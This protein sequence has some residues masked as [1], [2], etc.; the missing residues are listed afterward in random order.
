MNKLKIVLL[1][2]AYLP[3]AI[4]ALGN[5]FIIKD[6]I[7]Y[8]IKSLDNSSM[9][10]SRK[11]WIDDEKGK[12]YGKVVIE[13]NEFRKSKSIKARILSPTGKTLKKLKK[14]NIRVIQ[15]S[16]PGL[17]YTG[18]TYRTF[19]LS[20]PKTPYIIEYTYTIQFK[21]L[22]YWPNWFPQK[23]IS[24]KNAKYILTVPANIQYQKKVIGDISEPRHSGNNSLVWELSN[25][26]ASLNEYRTAPEDQY[27]YAILFSPSEFTLDGIRGS[28]SSWNDMGNWYSRLANSQYELDPKI[29]YDLNLADSLTTK[30]TIQRIYSYLQ[31][32]TRYVAVTLGIHGWK[33]HTAQS[34]CDNKYGDCKDLTTYFISLLKTQNI[35]AFPAL[36]LTRDKGIVYPD[37]PTSRFNHVITFIPLE[38]ETLWVDCTTD[39]TNIMDLPAN[40][41]GCNALVVKYGSGE[42]ISTPVS[43]PDDN[44]LIFRAD[45]RLM[46]DGSVLFRGSLTGTGN[47]AQYFRVVFSSKNDEDKRNTL[48]T[49]LGDNVPLIKLKEMVFDSS[50]SRT[51]TMKIEFEFLAAKYTNM[52]R[53][54]LFLS[55]SF[56][57]RTQYNYERPDKRQTA[58]FYKYPYIFKDFISYTISDDF[59]I[60]AIP[61]N[62]TKQYSFGKYQ[63]QI[64]TTNNRIAFTRHFQINTQRI[65]LEEYEN[66]FQFMKEAE[67]ADGGKIIL[68]RK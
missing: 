48:I 13:E 68:I 60:E 32:Q 50:D 54:R 42:L 59:V 23:D 61:T 49:W 4:L 65:E 2:H 9:T 62:V 47:V 51:D 36:L 56:Y 55:P 19:E 28:I 6:K 52:S 37:F 58:V 18:S 11:V 1:I 7:E 57:H 67:K 21:S 35:F 40:D 24:V 53:K 44:Q 3:C 39:F 64:N 63:Y 43:R 29:V 22:F 15:A 27:E 45:G 66:Y 10:V 16:P 46:T 30:E 5:S 20:Y 31:S 41:E 38:A 33:P 8:T 17:L 12:S 25:I 34:V 26:P 14:R